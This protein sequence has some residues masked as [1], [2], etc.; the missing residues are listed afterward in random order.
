M[1]KYV[2]YDTDYEG[3]EEYD[4]RG[5]AYEQLIRICCQYSTVLYLKYMQPDL[6]AV[7]LLKS[8]EIEKPQNISEDP[9]IHLPY[10]DKRYYRVC[11]ELCEVLL[12]V[13]DG[14]FEWLS[15]WGFENPEDPTFYRSDGTV[16]FVSVV[17]NGFCALIPREDEDLGGL[18]Q[19]VEWRTGD[20]IWPNDRL[21]LR[22]LLS[23]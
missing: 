1:E 4:I 8:F 15:G 16:F 6:Q 5:E 20:N 13:A 18:L 14:I 11:P 17:H 2:F 23:E 3:N 12:H 22:Y 9:V 7:D 10:C 19:A 21:W